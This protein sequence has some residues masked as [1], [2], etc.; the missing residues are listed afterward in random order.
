M[1]EAHDS[2][3]FGVR[4][5][6]SELRDERGLFVDRGE[7]EESGRSGGTETSDKPRATWQ[8]GVVRFGNRRADA[9]EHFGGSRA[10]DRKSRRPSGRIFESHVVGDDVLIEVSVD[11]FANFGRGIKPRRSRESDHLCV[12]RFDHTEIRR[13]QVAGY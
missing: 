2:S 9:G 1:F 12:D 13:C 10:F 11:A 6:D 3:G 7:D 5:F 8:E 4:L